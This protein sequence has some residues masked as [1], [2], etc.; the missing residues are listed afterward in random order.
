MMILLSLAKKVGEMQ[1]HIKMLYNI[2]YKRF[3]NSKEFLFFQGEIPKKLLVV[4][5]GKVRLYKSTQE[6][7]EETIHTISAVNFIAE[8]PS[9]MNIPYPA[10]AVC[11]EEC[12]ILEIELAFFKEYCTKNSDF[13]LS[14]IASLCHKIEIL[15]SLLTAST[16]SLK[17]KTIRFLIQNKSALANLS[18]RQIAQK[19]NTS[20]ES[21]SRILR[22]LKKQDCIQTQKGK[23]LLTQNAL[24]IC[25]EP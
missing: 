6:G 5:K 4:L 3:Y 10:S 22:E 2:G 12:E 7:K 14:F 18:Q 1:N 20:P 19:L 21:L 23:I 16:Q 25:E 15:E 17:E 9:F 11:L 13:C 24:K 8:M